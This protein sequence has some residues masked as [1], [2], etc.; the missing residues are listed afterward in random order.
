MESSSPE[1]RPKTRIRILAGAL[2]AIATHGASKLSMGEI[3]AAAGVSR[4]TL[5]RYFPTRDA[6]YAS[7]TEHEV[8]RYRAR[9]IEL[10]ETID[11]SEDAIQYVLDETARY[12][13]A[14]P[15]LNRLRETDMPLMF[16]WLRGEFPL[17]RDGLLGLMGPLLKDTSLVVSGQVSVGQLVDWITRAL[18]S[19][20]IF[21]SPEADDPAEGLGTVYRLIA[22][23]PQQGRRTLS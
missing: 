9:I 19:M 17:I 3:S 5:Y 20:L 22:Q 21:P 2:R 4:G 18:L 16:E 12:M 6:V 7:L 23:A 14:H 11:E 10:L 8:E 15:V 1:L 13:R